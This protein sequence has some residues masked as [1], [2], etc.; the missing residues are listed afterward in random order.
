MLQSA[1]MDDNNMCIS[2]VVAIG[3][4]KWVLVQQGIVGL[5]FQLNTNII[6][7][8]YFPS[9][10]QGDDVV[11]SLSTRLIQFARIIDI[12]ASL[13]WRERQ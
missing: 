4:S 3:T 1:F 13:I 6:I 7:Y 9:S 11:L 2:P 10:N 12:V 5:N 8:I